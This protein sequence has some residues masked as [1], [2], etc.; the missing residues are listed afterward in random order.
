[1]RRLLIKRRK[2][3]ALMSEYRRVFAD[4]AAFYEEEPVKIE[5]KKTK[6][7]PCERPHEA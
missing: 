7:L 2:P 4:N 1:M 3:K 5:K 6:R